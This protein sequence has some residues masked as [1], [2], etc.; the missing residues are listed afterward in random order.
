MVRA[1]SFLCISIALGSIPRV[2]DPLLAMNEKGY[3]GDADTSEKRGDD[4]T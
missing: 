3:C 2:L 4:E 1:L